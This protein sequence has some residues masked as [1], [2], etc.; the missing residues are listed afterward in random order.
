MRT[1]SL[2]LA[3]RRLNRS[4]LSEDCVSARGGQAREP[5]IGPVIERPIVNQK[6]ILEFTVQSGIFEGS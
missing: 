3:F 2:S 5:L 1:A 6:V 4:D